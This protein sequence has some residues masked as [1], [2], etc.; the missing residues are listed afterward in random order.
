MVT[1]RPVQLR[2]HKISVV[3]DFLYKQFSFHGPLRPGKN[4]SEDFNFLSAKISDDKY[5][6]IRIK[7]LSTH[8]PD[9]TVGPLEG[10]RYLLGEGVSELK[11]MCPGAEGDHGP[12]VPEEEV[13]P[14]Q[15]LLIVPEMSW[16][17]LQ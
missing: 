14:T 12:G 8:I 17:R 9:I 7:E 13:G 1:S 3:I 15:T 5:Q 6:N 16:F 10:G 2:H 11:L 4:L